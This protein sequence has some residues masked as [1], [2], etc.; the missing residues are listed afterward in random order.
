MG[1]RFPPCALNLQTFTKLQKERAFT[2]FKVNAVRLGNIFAR[3]IHALYYDQHY[4]R[5]YEDCTGNK[6]E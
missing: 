4:S 1:S 5:Y 6:L 2:F 3:N